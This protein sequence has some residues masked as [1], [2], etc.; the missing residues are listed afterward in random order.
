MKSKALALGHPTHP[1]L[2]PFP[3]AFLAGAVWFDVAGWIRN[4]PSWWKWRM[5]L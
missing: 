5:E 3:I 1:M 4:V 2:I